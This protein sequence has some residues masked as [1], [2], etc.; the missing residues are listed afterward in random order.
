MDKIIFGTDTDAV[1]KKFLDDSSMQ[2]AG[3]FKNALPYLLLI[4]KEN[5]DN[6]ISSSVDFAVSEL[7][8]MCYD[9]GRIK[10][11]SEEG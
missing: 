4:I 9:M 5:S 11:F 6:D 2:N 7:M 10:G 1:C 3:I 8:Q